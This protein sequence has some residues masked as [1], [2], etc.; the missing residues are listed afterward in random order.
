MPNAT[1]KITI[2]F[3]RIG[4]TLAIMGELRLV[5]QPQSPIFGPGNDCVHL[6]R[7]NIIISNLCTGFP[8]RTEVILEAGRQP[9]FFV[10]LTRC[11]SSGSWFSQEEPK[12]EPLTEQ[13][14]P[15]A[16]S[17]Q[18]AAPRSASSNVTP[19]ARAA[20]PTGTSQH[21]GELLVCVSQSCKINWSPKAP[22][23]V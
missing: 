2:P 18:R 6:V 1:H 7:R 20:A 8:C 12:P 11:S 9:Y 13:V 15:Q 17:E 16:S 5:E 21:S 4:G 23:V 14:A 10:F 3:S 22:K 19:A